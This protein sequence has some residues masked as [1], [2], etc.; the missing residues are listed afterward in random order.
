MRL[1]RSSE[2]FNVFRWRW[3]GA[4]AV[5]IPQKTVENDN[6]IPMDIPL[7]DDF[8]NVWRRMWNDQKIRNRWDLHLQ[9][10]LQGRATQRVCMASA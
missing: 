9:S 5:G 4:Q 2:T 1:W 3:V 6:G 7:M 8:P 10:H